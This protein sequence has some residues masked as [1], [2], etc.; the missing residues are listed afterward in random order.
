[1]LSKIKSCGLKGIEGFII[2]VETDIS[3]GIPAF[4]L[5]GLGDVAV[6]EAKERVRS[7][8][9]NTGYEF[10]TRRITVN[11]A[12]A[13]LRKEGSALDLPIAMGILAATGQVDSSLIDDYMIIGELSLDGQ[14][15][16]IN[17]V[18]SMVLCACQEGIRNV[19]LPKENADE[20]A[21]IENANIYPAEHLEDVILHVNGHRSIKR[22]TV[23]VKCLFDIKEQFYENDFSEVCGQENVKRVLE[24]AAAGSHSCLIM[25][26]PGSGKTMLARRLPS[27]LPPL[28]FDEALQVTRIHSIAGYLPPK[29]SLITTRPFRSPHHTISATS[30]IGGGKYPKP[31]EISL[32]HYGVLFLD[33]VFEFDKHTLEA[34]RQPLEDGVV[35]ISRLNGSITYPAEITLIL[36]GNPCPCGYRTDETKKCTCSYNE[37]QNYLSKLSGPLLDRID[38]YVE[39]MPVKY[40]EL[41]SIGNGENS[42]QIRQRVIRARDIQLER[43]KGYKIFSN[44]QLS[45]A[46]IKKFCKLD[47]KGNALLKNAFE[48]FNLSA[49]AYNRILKVARTIADLDESADIK[50]FHIAEAIQYRVTSLR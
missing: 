38:L 2:N 50:S 31:G 29:T 44:S 41:N 30:L 25:G 5:V 21:V 16:G 4:D 43:Y 19:I 22:H 42:S 14:I 23:D 18:L 8:I 49:R 39:A 47:S 46:L 28:T 35:T 10:P 11:L 36:T 37:I 15:K 20:A 32:A 26:I 45:G 17:G 7:A 40:K 3:N 48:K 13:N 9:K 1:M 33:E 24:I 27:I 6:R 12:P 34:M